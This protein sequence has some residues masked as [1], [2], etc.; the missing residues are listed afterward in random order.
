M[1]LRLT[2]YGAASLL[3][4]AFYAPAKAAAALLSGLRSRWRNLIPF[5]S[6]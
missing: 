1:R 5:R 6:H 4:L 3:L 2:I